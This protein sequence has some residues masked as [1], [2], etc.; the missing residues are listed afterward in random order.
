MRILLILVLLL[1]SCSGQSSVLHA[2]LM[3]P[4]K[5]INTLIIVG[6]G[7]T[8]GNLFN[9]AALTYQRENGGV[10]HEVGSGNEFVSVLKNFNLE[11][12]E[13]EHLEY[14]GHGNNVALFVNQVPGVNGSLYA[15]DP[16]YNE[17]Y[18]AASIYDL[19]RSVFSSAG[20]VTFNGCNLA[21]GHEVSD[22]F[23]QDMANHFQVVVTAAEG[24]T[25]FS[26]SPDAIIDFDEWR[27]LDLSES[28]DVY[29]LPTYLEEAF[30]VLHP[31]VSTGV[32]NDVY[33]GDSTTEAIDWL[34][35]QT[36]VFGEDFLPY[37]IASGKDVTELCLALS[38]VCDIEIDDEDQ[39][40]LDVLAILIDAHD[41]TP[42][43]TWPWYN[44]YVGLALQNEWMLEGFT[45]RR[46]MTRGE[47]A[48][49]AYKLSMIK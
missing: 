16:S 42:L 30:V 35:D 17:D 9:L 13:I 48:Y 12:G 38:L 7:G 26:S 40:T 44:S 4:L 32:Y 49:L 21:K 27:A 46:W 15:N 5:D 10:I 34:S 47:T 25:Q 2:D 3:E 20:T 41:L 36:L 6:E 39:K 24:P 33:H 19:D 14:F 43:Q 1:S 22:T 8:S 28:D 18:L 31:A 23:A 29:M 11:T 45:D 37:K